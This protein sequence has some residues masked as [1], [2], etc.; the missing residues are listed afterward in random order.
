M[1]WRA[2]PDY[3]GEVC[4]DNATRSNLGGIDHQGRVFVGLA[5]LHRYRN[6]APGSHLEPMVELLSD[7]DRQMAVILGKAM[8]FGAMFSGNNPE[9]MCRL[10]FRPKKKELKLVLPR[11]SADLYGEVAEAR[12]KSLASELGCEMEVRLAGD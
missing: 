7:K 3:R 8:R 12:F 4:F 10:E 5:L 9:A 1:S 2:H 6:A 11:A